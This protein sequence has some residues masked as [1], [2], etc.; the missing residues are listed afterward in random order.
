MKLCD[1]RFAKMNKKLTMAI[2]IIVTVLIS[3]FALL[4]TIGSL[5]NLE[6]W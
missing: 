2:I 3:I 6:I 5:Q 1:K 4:Y